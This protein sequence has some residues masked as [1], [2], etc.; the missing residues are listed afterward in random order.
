MSGT[1]NTHNKTFAQA[2]YGCKNK[3]ENV[4]TKSRSG[5]IFT[6]L[7]DIVLNNKGAVYGVVLSDDFTAKH[8][9]A[10]TPEQRDKMRGSKY[11]PSDLGD[12]FLDVER[13]LNNNLN[14]LFSGTPCQ[15]EGL[16]NYLKSKSVSTCNLLL[17]DI[18][19]HGVPSP[20]VWKKYL[21]WQE[22]RIGKKVTA[23]DFRNKEKFGWQEHIETLT[24]GNKQVHSKI[25]KTIYYSN[26]ILRP[27]CYKCPYK[28]INREADI[29]LGDFWGIDKRAADFND[30]KGVSLVLVNTEKGQRYFDE[31]RD[32]LSVKEFSR[33]EIMQNALKISYK[34]PSDRMIFWKSF[35]NESFDVIAKNY[36]DDNALTRLSVNTPAKLKKIM[37]K[38]I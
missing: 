37:K 35:N 5:G 38:I 17:V 1:F 33:D 23:A 11:I 29:T 30:N 36:G 2:F 16:K 22:N 4:R 20:E 21:V 14:V 15:I 28:S 18:I 25:F 3:D 32:A 31:I 8:I 12:T 7:S 26:Y 10:F 19:C 34:S 6:P 13:D 9:R 24:F 27:V